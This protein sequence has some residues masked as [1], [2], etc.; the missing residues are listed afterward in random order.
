[1]ILEIAKISVRPG[2][3]DDF[4]SGV[5][6]AAP[7][8]KR[9]KG[10]LGLSLRRCVEVPAD[11]LLMVEWETLEDHTVHFRQSDDYQHWR[12]LVSHCFATTPT[13]DHHAIVSRHF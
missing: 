8:F 7:L 5:A 9:A 11:Y 6:K 13:V 4:E 12:E 10:C 3:E 2:M 1:M